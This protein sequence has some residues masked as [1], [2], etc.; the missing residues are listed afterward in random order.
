MQ[1]R[2]AA[3]GVPDDLAES[4]WAVA[5]GNITVLDDLAQWWTLIRDGAVPLVDD[6]DRDFV[7]Q[8]MAMLPPRPWTR[9]TWGQ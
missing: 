1:A 3:L 9:D 8:A 2:I 7:A 4:F 5:R 6:A